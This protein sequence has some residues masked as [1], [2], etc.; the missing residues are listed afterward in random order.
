MPKVSNKTH[1]RGTAVVEAAVVVPLLL[2]L[3]LAIIEYGWLFLKAQQ[4]TNATR[5][6]ARVGIAWGASEDDI[7]AAIDTLMTSAGMTGKYD[8]PTISPADIAS[9]PAGTAITV[10][11]TVPTVNIALVNTTLLPKPDNI[12]ASVTMA[13]EGP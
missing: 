6:A 8:T 7:V 12:S 10:T 5:Q 4:T 2:T 9:L 3:T 11:L 1:C 13:K